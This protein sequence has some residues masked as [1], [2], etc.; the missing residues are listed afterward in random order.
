ME[1]IVKSLDAA[2]YGNG[3]PG[4]VVELTKI[5]AQVKLQT[6]IMSSLGGLILAIV[7]GVAIKLFA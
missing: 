6:K 5:Q 4:M 3:R 2:V 7:A 1:P